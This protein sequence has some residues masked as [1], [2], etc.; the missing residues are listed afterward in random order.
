[1]V[2]NFLKNALNLEIHE[3]G[4]EQRALSSCANIVALDFS[5]LLDDIK[6]ELPDSD[7]IGKFGLKRAMI[8]MPK[9]AYKGVVGDLGPNTC[10]WF[11][12]SYFMKLQAF[13]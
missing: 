11:H 9:L 3:Q 4:T 12:N 5:G 10:S 13:I 7:R 1:M 2:L 8:F 6:Q